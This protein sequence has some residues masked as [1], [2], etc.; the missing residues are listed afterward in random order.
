[1]LWS[2]TAGLELQPLSKGNSKEK[3]WIPVA[4][5]LRTDGNEPDQ[6]FG[7]NGILLVNI[8]DLLQKVSKGKWKSTPHRVPA[9]MLKDPENRDRLVLVNFIMLAPDFPLDE[10]GLTQGEHAFSHFKRAGRNKKSGSQQN[11]NSNADSSP[12]FVPMV[13]A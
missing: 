10:S 5:N 1:L 4:Q 2:D 9:P 6:K 3:K 12:K 11:S 7:D 13:E 8:G